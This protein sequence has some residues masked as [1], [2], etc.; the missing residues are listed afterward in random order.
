MALPVCSFSAACGGLLAGVSGSFWPS[1]A[2]NRAKAS[3]L[4]QFVPPIRTI[5]NRT[6]RRFFVIRPWVAQR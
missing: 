1:F 2:K 4:V 3:M 6:D 5:S